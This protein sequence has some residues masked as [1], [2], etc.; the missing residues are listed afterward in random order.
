MLILAVYPK[1]NLLIY[2]L[3]GSRFF[4][5]ILKI[6]DFTAYCD[7]GNDAFVEPDGE[8]WCENCQK[9]I[10]NPLIENGFI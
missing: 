9:T 3:S 2:G 1:A 10:K 5:E 4:C 6:K 7:C 8:G